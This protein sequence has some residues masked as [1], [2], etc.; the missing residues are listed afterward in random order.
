MFEAM[1]KSIQSISVNNYIFLTEFA[2]NN[3]WRREFVQ[4]ECTQETKWDLAMMSHTSVETQ[5]ND[6]LRTILQIIPKQT[7]PFP[8]LSD[9]DSH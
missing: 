8:M 3:I 1:C 6:R 4:L 9:S 2:Y 7:W 5:N